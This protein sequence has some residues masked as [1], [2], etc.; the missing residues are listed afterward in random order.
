MKLS[1]FISGLASLALLSSA[2]FGN[3]IISSTSSVGSTTYPLSNSVLLQQFNPTLGNLQSVTVDLILSGNEVTTFT[4]N[5]ETATIASISSHVELILTLGNTGFSADLAN[6]PNAPGN[7]WLDTNLITHTVTN[8]GPLT[9]ASFN[10]NFTKS[11]IS[12]P[13]TN[14]LVFNELQGL[15]T[16]QLNFG[17]IGSFWLNTSDVG[18]TDFSNVVT[19][20]FTAIVTYDYSTDTPEPGTMVMSLIPVIGIV[21]VGIRKKSAFVDTL[22]CWFNGLV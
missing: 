11:A 14:G 10:S 9:T 19:G 16:V 2:A 12:T 1:T 17:A 7:P 6:D 3:V 18:N 20:D 15:G 13:I 22:K 5:S 8:L 4:N 21:T